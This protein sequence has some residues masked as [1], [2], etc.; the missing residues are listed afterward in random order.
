MRLQIEALWDDC[1]TDN[2]IR[3]AL[4]N[5]PKDLD[6]TYRRCL[7]R[8]ERNGDTNHA[9]K[10]FQW[11]G[12]ASRSL[13]SSE[14]QEAIAFTTTD[15]RWE[16]GRTQNAKSIVGRCANLVVL[17]AVDQH[18]RFAHPS[19]LQYIL[20][21]TDHDHAFQIDYKQGQLKCAEFS[22]NYLN[23][24][25]FGLPLQK[26]DRNYDKV[27]NNVLVSTTSLGKIMGKFAR[28]RPRV[29]A[30]ST[31]AN[32]SS[33]TR[34][35]PA[36]GDTRFKFLSYAAENWL[37]DS[38]F[39]TKQSRMWD[40]FRSLALEPNSSWKVHPWSSDGVS[41]HSHLHGLLGWAVRKR[42]IPLLEILIQSNL[43]FKT[44]ELCRKSLVEDGLP[45]L[46]AA[47]KL[48]YDDVVTLLLNVA[49]VNTLDYLQR[50]AL[51]H[52]AE[53]GHS[54]VTR[55]LS[56]TK[57]IKVN[58]LST[59][60]IT[61]AKQG[62]VTIVQLLL[63]AGAKVKT[64]DQEQRTALSWAA[65][66]GHTAVMNLLLKRTDI[67]INAKDLSGRTPCSYAAEAGYEEALELLLTRD[68]VDSSCLTKDGVSPLGVAVENGH[69]TAVDL[70]LKRSDIDVNLPAFLN[71]ETPLFGAVR[72]N[73]EAMVKFFLARG[74]VI[75]NCSDKFG[76]TPL[77][78]AIKNQNKTITKLLLNQHDIDVNS[79]DQTGRTAL[80]QAIEDGCE[81]ATRMLLEKKEIQ[82]NEADNSGYTPLHWTIIRNDDI[83][84][85]LLLQRDDINVNLAD[86][87]GRT[88]LNLAIECRNIVMFRTLL[89]QNEIDVN[90][91]DRDG[92]TPLLI[93]VD[94]GNFEIT[95][96]LLSL[97]NDF[98][99]NAKD[100]LGL[101][102]LSCAIKGTR[103]ASLRV[104]RQAY[105]EIYRMMLSYD[106]RSTMRFIA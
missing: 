46:H 36:Q 7:E 51:D 22:I 66:K 80:L 35:G 56:T 37:N 92:R 63:G 49:E 23:F 90:L 31:L 101:T 104:Q 34:L 86:R 52:A 78:K 19:M 105:D 96:L 41:Y 82:V 77:M 94:V 5:L 79:K 84:S 98:N 21:R 24:S 54:R 95:K 89:Q 62:H 103:N 25:N 64:K 106:E 61:A 45:A 102:P 13:H 71:L 68:S 97:R 91:A 33:V 39:I 59:S 100:N 72:V 9:L 43:E 30:S 99:V 16:S 18:V 17:D 27:V 58:E 10:V 26:T 73:N 4:E 20:R 8:I 3:A 53:K 14:I 38:K 12:C 76:Q 40:N 60:L 67:D 93:A 44:H 57:G 70:L 15:R 50:T 42:H 1:F 81:W 87:R 48:G 11:V 47:S 74:D 2:D 55:I 88:P 69:E 85:N 29:T 28:H 65:G 32:S 83:M 6:A 75:V